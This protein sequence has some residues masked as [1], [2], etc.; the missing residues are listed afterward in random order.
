VEEVIRLSQTLVLVKLKHFE[1]QLLDRMPHY[2]L[3]WVDLLAKASSQEF[4]HAALILLEGYC[5]FCTHKCFYCGE[6]C[7]GYDQRD[8]RARIRPEFL[9]EEVLS[10]ENND[11]VEVLKREAILR[12]TIV[13]IQHDIECVRLTAPVN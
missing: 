1:Q 2:R 9:G 6:D 13:E 8:Q 12:S 10:I 5:L 4:L 3:A 7:H 11:L